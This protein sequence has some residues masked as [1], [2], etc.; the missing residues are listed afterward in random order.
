MP[1]KVKELAHKL[2]FT[3][4]RTTAALPEPAAKMALGKADDTWPGFPSLGLTGAAFALHQKY[5]EVLWDSDMIDVRRKIAEAYTPS[6]TRLELIEQALTE[7][8]LVIA[9]FSRQETSDVR[10][11]LILALYRYKPE[12]L[13]NAYFLRE[14]GKHVPVL[15]KLGE[16]AK[17]WGQTIPGLSV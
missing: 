1:R 14:G 8:D 9:G 10:S 3:Y 6:M 15:D 13:H 17:F 11:L 12:L 7:G 4:R 2:F 5:S 16:L